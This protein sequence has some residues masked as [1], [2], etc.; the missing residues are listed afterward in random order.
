[1]RKASLLLL[2]L[3]LAG[4][5]A[6][7]ELEARKES[8]AVAAAPAPAPEESAEIRERRKLEAR[9]DEANAKIEEIEKRIEEEPWL[10]PPVPPPPPAGPVDARVSAVNADLNIVVISAGRDVGVA[11]GHVF[12]VWRDNRLLGVLVVDKVERDFASGYMRIP[13]AGLGDW[14][15]S[16]DEIRGPR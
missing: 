13:P 8:E 15:G 14:P 9:L 7:A 3:A 6:S 5:A 16:G 11:A 10:E 4:C 12:E 2:A 1:M